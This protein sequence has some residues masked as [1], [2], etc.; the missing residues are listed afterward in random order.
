MAEEQQLYLCFKSPLNEDQ[1]KL[2]IKYWERDPQDK[3][4]F[5]YKREYLKNILGFEKGHHVSD[6]IKQ[7]CYVSASSGK[8]N[9]IS[10]SK[11]LKANTR[12]ELVNFQKT[13][14]YK[15]KECQNSEENLPR[16]YICWLTPA[17]Q[18]ETELIYKYWELKAFE[19]KKFRYQLKELIDILNFTKVETIPNLIKEKCFISS[20]SLVCIKCNQNFTP[21]T[22]TE[23]IHLQNKERQVCKKCKKTEVTNYVLMEIE[24][25]NSS[26]KQIPLPKFNESNLQNLDYLNSLALLSM[27]LELN[28]SDTTQPV[29]VSKF[30]LFVSGNTDI[31]TQIFTDLEHQKAIHIVNDN[32]TTK[33]ST[34]YNEDAYLLQNIDLIDTKLL[35]KLKTRSL[36]TTMPGFYFSLPDCF[37]D[38]DEYKANLFE[39]L[40][41]T[42]IT[43]DDIE[44]I[45]EFVL[46][47]RLD[48]VYILLGIVK[49]VIKIP[50][51]MNMKLDT[52][53][54]KLIKKYPLPVIFNILSYQA[55]QVASK[56]YSNPSMIYHIQKQQLATFLETHI[57]YLEENDKAILYKK[58]LPDFM[59]GSMIEGFTSYYVFD[60]LTSWTDLSANEVIEK[61][62]NSPTVRLTV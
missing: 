44:K 41:N 5:K 9:C 26:I 33:I 40:I 14:I 45:Q 16:F 43:R 47:I 48:Q 56:L 19:N 51:D 25:I 23:F 28:P 27:L 3:K 36:Q 39:Q 17:D 20:N 29:Q 58:K 55:K 57:K 1:L 46:K 61:W 21:N 42:T 10:C 30:E 2:I 52:V 18:R 11:K 59:V 53:F 6:F 4:K 13:S 15:C 24:N 62:L 22:R 54:V 32:E 31:D 34:F 38:F 7:T 12:S 60:G 35:Q 50:I 49:N 8:F 37:D